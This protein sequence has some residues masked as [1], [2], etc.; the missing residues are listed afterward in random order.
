MLYLL[1]A[2]YD[3]DS[4]EYTGAMARA[5]RIL[6]RAGTRKAVQ[7]ATTS[8]EILAAVQQ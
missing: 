7:A 5:T 3:L 6:R 8:A 2:P 4:A 1:V